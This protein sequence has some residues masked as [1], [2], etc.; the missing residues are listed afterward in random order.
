[1]F[2]FGRRGKC[3]R[4]SLDSSLG[5]CASALCAPAWI[6]GAV[7]WLSPLTAVAVPTRYEPGVDPGL[8]VNLISWANFGGAG[9]QVWRD[10]VQS[11]YDAG[12]REVSL[13]LLRFVEQADAGDPPNTSGTIPVPTANAPSLAHVAAGVTK[14][15]QLGMTV[16][17]NPMI[18]RELYQGGPRGIRSTISLNPTGAQS[19]RFWP[20]YEAYVVDVAQMAQAAGADR[21]LV[22]SEL[23]GLSTNAGHAAKWDLVIDSVAANFMRQIGYA[24]AFD[25]Y[26]HPSTTSAIW[27]HPAIDFMG[28]DAY[29]P[30][31]T[32][33][34]SDSS[35]TLPNPA[36][37]EVVRDSWN[38]LL[39]DVNTLN[40]DLSDMI[41]FAEARHGNAGLPIVLTEAGYL[42]YNRAAM[43]GTAVQTNPAVV[44]QD[45]QIMALDGMLQAL[46][47]RRATDDLLA[48]NIRQW[49]MPGAELTPGALWN[50]F[51][52][53]AGDAD[54]NV[55]ATQFLMGLVNDPLFIAADFDSDGDVDLSDLTKWRTGFGT[56]MGATKVNGDANADGD[57]DGD[58]FLM[59]QR[60]VGIGTS[61]AAAAPEPA[62]AALGAWGAATL[63]AAARR[64]RYVD[65]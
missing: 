54:L 39:D 23:K 55:P 20:A 4:F 9:E 2:R 19:D 8:G 33:V 61:A 44:D 1:M 25:E 13:S 24:A 65:A 11:A 53:T 14:A 34:P 42:P 36:F 31:T 35:G 47:R 16:T 64:R 27:E 10:A 32:E 60:Q 29:F 57:V 15:K 56:K 50:M 48:V 38:H 58:D 28:V 43:Q 59:W 30:M 46:D 22:G 5:R 40:P 52:T 45:E 6:V 26:K 41:D 21:M 37:V 49:S 18:E 3:A 12:F 17:V 62:S 63:L 51:P 7:A